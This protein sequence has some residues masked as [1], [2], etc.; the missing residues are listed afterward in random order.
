MLRVMLMLAALAFFAMPG[1][2]VAES[3][4]EMG[5]GCGANC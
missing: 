1:Q 2:T 3:R 5:A 4:G